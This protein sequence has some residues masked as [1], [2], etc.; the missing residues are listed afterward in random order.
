M[1]VKAISTIIK[2]DTAV[3][4][5]CPEERCG[6]KVV[7]EN[8]G[9]YRCEKC[10]KTYNNFKWAYMVS[11]ELSDT[12]GAQW[13]TVFRNDAEALLGITADEF[14]NHKVNQNDSII[15]DIVRKAMNRE[16]IFKLRAKAEQFNDERKIRFTCMSI[17][18]VDWSSHGRRLI[19][20]IKQLQPVQY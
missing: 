12:T 14:G 11:A 17:S 8:N 5:M 19:E 9:T 7:D 13:I 18:D 16:R 3:Y 2:K 10:N 6:K 15:E 1:N 4:M 20:E